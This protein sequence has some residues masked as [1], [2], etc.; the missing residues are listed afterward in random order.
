MRVRRAD[1]TIQPYSTDKAAWYEPD[2]SH[3]VID[4]TFDGVRSTI[5]LRKVDMSK[6]LLTNRGFHWINEQPFNR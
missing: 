5:R 1:D 6:F 4:G 2:A 3:I